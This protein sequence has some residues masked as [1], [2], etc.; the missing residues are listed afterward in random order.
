MSPKPEGKDKDKDKDVPQPNAV[1]PDGTPVY[2]VPELASAPPPPVPVDD[3]MMPISPLDIPHVEPPRGKRKYKGQLTDNM[4]HANLMGL[5][6]A[7]E[8]HV[9]A[10]PDR[11][12][13]T[14]KT[15]KDRAQGEFHYLLEHEGADPFACAQCT[16]LAESLYT[17][18]VTQSP[19]EER[20]ATKKPRIP[21]DDIVDDTP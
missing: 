20:L 6:A 17:L 2:V 4:K 12:V 9:F 21:E 7:L 18:I 19:V 1:L 3:V 10:F 13:I 11:P 15:I 16:I 14:G 5:H 8:E